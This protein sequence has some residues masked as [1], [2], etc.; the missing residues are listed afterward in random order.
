[1][2]KLQS[3]MDALVETITDVKIDQVTVLPSGDNS[4]AKRADLVEEF[5]AGTGIDI[6]QVVDRMTG[7]PA[8]DNA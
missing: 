2:Q 8:K 3:M 5:K 7:G 6:P 1:M 4:T